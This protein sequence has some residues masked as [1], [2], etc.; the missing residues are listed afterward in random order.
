MWAA[1]TMWSLIFGNP[2]LALLRGPLAICALI[3]T[4]IA[5]CGCMRCCNS[6]HW[7][8]CA[9]LKHILRCIGHDTFDEF[10][11]IVLVHEAMFDSAKKDTLTTVVQIT[12]GA[13]T[14]KTSPNKSSVFE[15]PLHITV[16]QG[17]EQLVVDLLTT[18]SKLLATVK[19]DVYEIQS[20]TNLQPEIVYQM[21]QKGKGIQNPRIKLTMVASSADDPERGLISS[22]TRSDVSILVRQQLKKAQMKPGKEGASQMDVLKEACSGPLE[23]FEGSRLGQTQ[24]VYVAVVGPPISRRWVM[25]IWRDQRDFLEKKRAI[26]EVPLL[27]IQSIQADQKR[28]HVFVVNFF[29]DARNRQTLTFRRVDRN[30][31]VWVEILHLLVLKA[32][33]Q[34]NKQK[35]Q[36]DRSA[37]S[38]SPSPTSSYGYHSFGH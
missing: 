37:R 12:A 17:T 28:N 29:D 8:D 10:E 32:R 19:I 16:E 7:R 20:E 13:H 18:S 9:V 36:R 25:G 31:D 30:R 11:L 2:L 14:V 35:L 3:G 27:K 23:S 22:T 5:I 26:K 6:C 21:R 24:A 33:E 38:P 15:Q 4:V 34:D 1:A